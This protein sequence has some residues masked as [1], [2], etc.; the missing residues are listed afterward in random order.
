[1]FSAYRDIFGIPGALKFSAAGLI[2]RLPIA[3]LGLGV[4]LFIQAE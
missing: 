3:L 1:M 4:V 2:A